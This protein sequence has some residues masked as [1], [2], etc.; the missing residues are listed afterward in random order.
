MRIFRLFR[1]LS[2]TSWLSISAT[3]PRPI[4]LLETKMFT[5][6]VIAHT[7]VQRST[8]LSWSKATKAFST[9]AFFAS[10]ARSIESGLSGCCYLNRYSSFFLGAKTN[11]HSLLLDFQRLEEDR[12][13]RL[14]FELHGH[15]LSYNFRGIKPYILSCHGYILPLFGMKY[16]AH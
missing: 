6:S 7:E 13:T 3:S 1:R 14:R 9:S 4:F 8:S 12:F 10:S 16:F 5:I 11:R 2:L 15:R